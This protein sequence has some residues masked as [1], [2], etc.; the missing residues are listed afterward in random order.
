[1]ILDV[2]GFPIYYGNPVEAVMYFKKMARQIGSE[3][4]ECTECG[5]VNP[6]QVFNII[7]TKIVDEYG[8][9]T[10]QR[11]RAPSQWNEGYKEN[12]KPQKNK[13]NTQ[14]P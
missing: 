13:K 7:E 4:G 5:N 9:F 11:K 14:V 2:G 3:H 1:M 10:D 8:R 6:E 12:I